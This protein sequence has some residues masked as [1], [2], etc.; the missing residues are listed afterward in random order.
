MLNPNL[1]TGVLEPHA[2]SLT[3]QETEKW[4]VAVPVVAIVGRPNVGK[5]SLFNAL[6][7]RRIAIV[8]PT[9]GVTRDRVSTLI[10]AGERFFE[11]VDTGGIGVQDIDNL[12]AH[13]E[14]QIETAIDAAAVILFVVDVR[15][16]TTSLDEQV[17]A[18]LRY[19][20]KPTFCV[21]NK[22]DSPELDSQAAEFYKLGRGKLVCVSAE[23]KRGMADLIELILGRLPAAEDAAPNVDVRL[24]L[25]IVGRRNT[26]KS[27]FINSL[28]QSER[29]IVS[30]VPGTTRDSV[31]V[32]FERD[33]QVFIAIDTAGV[34]RK[35]SIE[36]NVEFYSMARAERSIRRAD[37]ALLFL[38][39]QT[40]I[41]KVDKQLAGYILEQ[42]CPAI[43]VV[44]KWDLMVPM[45]TEKYGNYI[46]ATFP[47]LD[48][49][50]IAFITAK[51]GK[52][53]QT[54][55]NL[56][57]NIHKQA[58]AR[59]ATGDLNR[60]VRAALEQQS[61][62]LRQNR[63]PKVYY[64]TQVATNP[65]TIV[66]MTN[67]PELFDLTYQ[68]Y[69]LKAFRDQLPFSEVPIKLYLRRKRRGEEVPEEQETAV[70]DKPAKRGKDPRLDLSKLKFQ[71]TLS[72]EEAQR[73]RGR[74]ESEL[75]KDL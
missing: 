36:T 3:R 2:N 4:L 23:Q 17:A 49:V 6:A 67:G 32:R 34:R 19:V 22:C 24:K 44:N 46:R 14:R 53:V 37:V 73:D 41:S 25:A 18:R 26:G 60:V 30:E 66:L 12:T 62:P 57:Q 70:K 52:N 35:S 72:E 33:G 42:H 69:L 38:D 40:P 29:M 7:G 1:E 58:S 45:P 15:S 39:P 75:W 54:V 68:R 63:R 65:P 10:K 59:V 56:A 27:T 51:K 20:T 50:P 31:D 47:S 9:A 11:L 61:P 13:I 16:G 5:S 71:S 74:Y 8:D 28:A 21:A 64:V 43:F 48:Y 55:L